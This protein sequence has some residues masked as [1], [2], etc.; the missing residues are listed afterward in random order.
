MS[1]LEKGVGCV[2]GRRLCVVE[3][4]VLRLLYSRAWVALEKSGLGLG[5][6][7]RVNSNQGR[8]SLRERRVSGV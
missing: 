2:R 3:G 5:L 6:R 7:V 4:L 1:A 8:A